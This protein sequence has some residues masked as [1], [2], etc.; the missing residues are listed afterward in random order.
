MAVVK[1]DTADPGGCQN[2]C[3]GFCLIDPA[4]CVGLSV[5]IQRGAVRSK[6]VTPLRFKSAHKRRAEHSFMP[7]DVNAF[8]H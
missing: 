8:A 7:G 3:I 6:D 2:N 4:L 1:G 5:E